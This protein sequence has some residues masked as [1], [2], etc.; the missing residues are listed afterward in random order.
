MMSL[1]VLGALVMACSKSTTG[2]TDVRAP[3]GVVDASAPARTFSVSGTVFEHTVTNTRP[4]A[5]LHFTVGF[6]NRVQVDVVSDANGRYE[7]AGFPDGISILLSVF[8]DQ[9]YRAPCPV[10]IALLKSNT[11]LDLHVVSQATLITAGLPASLPTPS[12]LPHVL[13]TVFEIASGPLRPAGGADVSLLGWDG[14]SSSSTLSG[15]DGRYLVCLP[16]DNEIPPTLRATKQGYQANVESVV[17][18][19]WDQQLDFELRR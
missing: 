6:P 13:G 2:P 5:G 9:D 16:W 17:L 8:P 15:P 12:N 18:L 19:S 3:T 14:Y 1:L 11:L 10:P 4:L 7:A